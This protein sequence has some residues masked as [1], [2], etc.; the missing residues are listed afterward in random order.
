MPGGEFHGGVP[1]E[2]AA[3]ED[4]ALGYSDSFVREA[5]RRRCLHGLSREFSPTMPGARALS[6][7]PDASRAALRRLLLHLS[8]FRGR[9]LPRLHLVYVHTPPDG[10][11]RRNP[12]GRYRHC[13]RSEVPRGRELP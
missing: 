13:R 2:P 1:L 6:S 7:G 10:G 8:E 5:A 3:R 4:A 11:E 12:L 9:I